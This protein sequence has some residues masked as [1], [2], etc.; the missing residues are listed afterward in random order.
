MTVHESRFKNLDLGLSI[1]RQ[2]LASAL[3][4]LAAS[5][6]RSVE[7]YILISLSRTS[8]L[9]IDVHLR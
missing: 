2:L 6:V 4:V 5:G 8:Q 3:A 9:H 1:D 7:Y